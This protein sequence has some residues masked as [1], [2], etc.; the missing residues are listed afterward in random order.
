MLR[1]HSPE[2]QNAHS[3]ASKGNAFVIKY[4]ELDQSK[5][6]NNPLVNIGCTSQLF[7]DGA[8]PS[9]RIQEN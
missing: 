8:V 9:M 3:A 2:S 7:V 4:R 5:K 1:S 6:L